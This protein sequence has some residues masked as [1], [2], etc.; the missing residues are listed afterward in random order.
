MNRLKNTWGLFNFEEPYISPNLNFFSM[1]FRLELLS[2]KKEPTG[3]VEP[4][5]SANGQKVDKELLQDF[6]GNGEQVASLNPEQA[7]RKH[8][9]NLV[10]EHGEEKALELV[11]GGDFDEVGKQEIGILNHFGLQADDFVVSVGCGSG[12]LA[13]PLSKVHQGNYL[14]I[15]VVPQ[16]LEHAKKLVGRKGGTSFLPGI[17]PFRSP[18]VRPTLFA[19]F[20]IHPPPSRAVIHLFGDL[21]VLKP[22]GKVVFSYW[23]FPSLIM[24]SF[25]NTAWS[26]IAKACL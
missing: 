4:V 7:Y 3:Q 12:R 2:T 15:D 10:R 25:S 26:V 1:A 8:Y 16:A 21:R 17:L 24:T 13:I 23:I 11:V 14:G 9:D 5:A 18:M 19:F 22:G 20:R 6:Q